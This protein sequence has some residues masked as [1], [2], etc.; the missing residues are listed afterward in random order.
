MPIAACWARY[1]AISGQRSAS[2]C[3]RAAPDSGWLRDWEGGGWKV[4]QPV[5]AD[6]AVSQCNASRQVGP[7]HKRLRWTRVLLKAKK[8]SQPTNPWF[9]ILSGLAIK[10]PSRHGQYHLEISRLEKAAVAITPQHY[11]VIDPT[12]WGR[13]FEGEKRSHH[14][15]QGLGSKKENAPRRVDLAGCCKA[16]YSGSVSIAFASC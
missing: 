9:G 2:G 16:Q 15:L 10:E 5:H 8:P 14:F 6:G 4:R 7:A 1:R 11:A 12:G 13:Q 3:L